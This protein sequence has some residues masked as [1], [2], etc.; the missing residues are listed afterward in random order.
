MI[1]SSAALARIGLLQHLVKFTG[2]L[3]SNL[4]R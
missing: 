2:T 3:R 4:E 1:G